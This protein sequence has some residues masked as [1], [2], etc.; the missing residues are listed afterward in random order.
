MPAQS[1]GPGLLGTI[2]SVVR[3]PTISC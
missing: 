1:G 3:R 2:G